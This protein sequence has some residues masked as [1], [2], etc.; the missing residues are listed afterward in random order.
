M[1]IEEAI[2]QFR[3]AAIEKADFAR[4]ASRDHALHAA[5][6]SAWLVLEDHGVAGRDAFASLLWDESVHVRGWAAAQLLA[7][8]DE[9]A[10]P[11]L[12]ADSEATGLPGL[13]AKTVLQE[14]RAGRLKPPLGERGA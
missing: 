1:R 10:V 7:L 13:S 5:M 2:R 3:R 12:E 8:G 6:A 9:R 14:W 11:S 4:P